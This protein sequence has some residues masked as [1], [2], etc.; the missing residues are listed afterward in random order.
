MTKLKGRDIT[1]VDMYLCNSDYHSVD[2]EHSEMYCY[3]RLQENA[4]ES[5][6]YLTQ[7]TGDQFL[8]WIHRVDDNVLPDTI[9]HFA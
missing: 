8:S 4:N 9:P 3:E 6:V 2:L 1:Y 5:R 7:I